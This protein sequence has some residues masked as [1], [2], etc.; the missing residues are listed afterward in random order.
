MCLY[1]ITNI[2]ACFA[3]TFGVVQIHCLIK[4]GFF[5]TRCFYLIYGLLKNGFIQWS[6]CKKKARGA[7]PRRLKTKILKWWLIFWYCLSTKII[8]II[9]KAHPHWKLI[10]WFTE[11]GQSG[12]SWSTHAHCLTHAQ[13]LGPSPS[14][15]RVLHG[16]ERS[17]KKSNLTLTLWMYEKSNLTLANSS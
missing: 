17:L 8:I 13:S 11:T 14:L 16:C 3:P 7:P 10:G 9:I 2:Q 5:S 15:S 12:C 1:T 6:S 4:N